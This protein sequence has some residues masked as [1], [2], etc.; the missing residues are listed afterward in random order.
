MTLS[1]F[2]KAHVNSFFN[3]LWTTGPVVYALSNAQMI[4]LWGKL[5]VQG[6]PQPGKRA[7]LR[8]R[9]SAVLTRKFRVLCPPMGYFSKFSTRRDLFV[10]VFLK[11]RTTTR[12]EK[13]KQK[14]KR[15]RGKTTATA[16][17]KTKKRR[18]RRE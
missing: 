1:A 6:T 14:K 18:E 2:L 8:G 5:A 10:F 9:F 13:M 4:L 3:H 12:R 11:F 16:R 17:R 7:T 15:R